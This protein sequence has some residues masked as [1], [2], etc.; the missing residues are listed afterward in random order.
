MDLVVKVKGHSGDVINEMVD[1]LAKNA[2]SSNSYFNNRFNYSNRIVRYFPTFKQFPIEYNL[3]K[4][5]KTLMNIRMADL[6]VL[7][8]SAYL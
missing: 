1:K 3:R 6:I 7:Q 5:I 2:C 8:D 4:F